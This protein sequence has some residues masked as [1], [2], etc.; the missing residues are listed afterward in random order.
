MT[1]LQ[2]LHS[3]SSTSHRAQTS[4][5]CALSTQRARETRTVHHRGRKRGRPLGELAAWVLAGSQF[6]TKAEHMGMAP[7]AASRSQAR[8][9]LKQNGDLFAEFAGLEAPKSEGEESE[10]A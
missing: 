9:D 7:D 1:G 10:P 5:L 8:R 4:L 6:G 2:L 3:G